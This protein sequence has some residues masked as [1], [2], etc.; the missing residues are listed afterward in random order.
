MEKFVIRSYVEEK[1]W[2]L[3]YD[4][5]YKLCIAIRSAIQKGGE[6]AINLLFVPKM[7]LK[8]ERNLLRGTRHFDNSDFRFT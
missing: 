2:D 7:T 3:L 5:H 1:L 6:S 8:I 4:S